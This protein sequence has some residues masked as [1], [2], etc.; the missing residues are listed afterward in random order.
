MALASAAMAPTVTPTVVGT[1]TPPDDVTVTPTTTDLAP[2]TATATPPAAA[3]V[4]I[5]SF[6]FSPDPITVT[7]GTTV[8][9]INRDPVPHTSTSGRPG[10]PD[11][12]WDSGFLN[13]GDAYDHT[14][15]AA[16]VFPYYCRIHPTMLGTA[17]LR[18]SDSAVDAAYLPLVLRRLVAGEPAI[19]RGGGSRRWW[20]MPP[21][22]APIPSRAQRSFR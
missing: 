14:F 20:I 2:S 5:A 3:A 10:A 22:M 17:I 16:G 11:G 7:V 8:E 6:A 21:G 1:A 13:P 4:E 15:L 9:W 18:S 12:R 19:E